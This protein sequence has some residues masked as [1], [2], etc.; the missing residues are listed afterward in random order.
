MLHLV[1]PIQVKKKAQRHF[2]AS[3]KTPFRVRRL[4]M[5]P[6]A[7]IS[8]LPENWLL[9]LPIHFTYQR[10][11]NGLGKKMGISNKQCSE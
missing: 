2:Q 1:R 7:G 4:P 3:L 10:T 9:A 5:L 8:T 11:R 6:Q